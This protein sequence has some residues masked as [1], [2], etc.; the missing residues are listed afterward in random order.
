MFIYNQYIPNCM[1]SH[2]NSG[3]IGDVLHTKSLNVS[4]MPFL[5]IIDRYHFIIVIP[6]NIRV[7]NE[8]T[9]SLPLWSIIILHTTMKVPMLPMSNNK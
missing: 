7:K 2:V 8:I 6:L 1:E 5:S 9:R 3:V 4:I